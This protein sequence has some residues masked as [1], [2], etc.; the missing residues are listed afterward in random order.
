[1]GRI[2]TVTHDPSARDY[3]GTSPFEWGGNGSL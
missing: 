3:A 1:M 2:T